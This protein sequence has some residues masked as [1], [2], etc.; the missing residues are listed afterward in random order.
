M[1]EPQSRGGGGVEIRCFQ[2]GMAVVTDIS[3]ALVIRHHEDNVGTAR[4]FALALVFPFAR[5]DR[6]RWESG[7]EQE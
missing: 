5:F 1:V 2:M 4:L 3:P 6:P 7:D